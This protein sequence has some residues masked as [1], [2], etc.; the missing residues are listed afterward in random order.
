MRWSDY[1]EQN[2]NK[3]NGLGGKF[4]FVSN[5]MLAKGPLSFRPVGDDLEVVRMTYDEDAKKNRRPRPGDDK[6]QTKVLVNAVFSDDK[7]HVAVLP[8]SVCD[9]Y[10][11][12]CENRE[13]AEVAI[14]A[15]V[16]GTGL[17]TRYFVKPTKANVRATYDPGELYDLRSAYEELVGPLTEAEKAET[18]RVAAADF[19]TVSR[20]D[21]RDGI[22]M[23]IPKA[24]DRDQ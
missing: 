9:K 13:Q 4:V 3:A 17:S 11:E 24:V 5:K 7:V 21:E 1:K 8:K 18:E 22:G 6:V 14:E 15:T 19:D 2:E 23:P 16:T 12:V 20:S 10:Q